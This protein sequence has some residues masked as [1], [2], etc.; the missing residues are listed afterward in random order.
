[1][2]IDFGDNLTKTKSFDPEE[3]VRI[4]LEESEEIPPTGLPVGVNGEICYIK[5][6][7]EVA[8]KRKFIE[9]LNKAETEVPIVNPQTRAIEGYRKKLRFPYRVL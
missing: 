1:M 7:E 5:P 2:A 9:V 6:G 8:L 4:I 3:R